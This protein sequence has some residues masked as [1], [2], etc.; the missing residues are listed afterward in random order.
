MKRDNKTCIC[1]GKSYRYCPNCA[2]YEHLEKWHN[3]YDNENCKRLFDITS[4]YYAKK[5]SSTEA[6]EKFE[7]CDLSY[8]DKLNKSILA[9]MKEVDMD[10]DAKKART[11]VAET[12]AVKSENDKSEESITSKKKK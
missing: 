11:S 4:D 12:S 7:E 9:A 1:C 2:E 10:T 6:K 8:S 3:L 5:I